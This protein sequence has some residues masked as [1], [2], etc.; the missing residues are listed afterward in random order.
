MAARN[1][2]KC[3]VI[4]SVI[5]TSSIESFVIV[6]SKVYTNKDIIV[7][8]PQIHSLYLTYQYFSGRP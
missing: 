8:T 7:Y 6:S 4:Y 3:F 2:A 5:C 1:P